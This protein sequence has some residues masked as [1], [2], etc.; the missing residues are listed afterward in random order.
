MSRMRSSKSSG[1]SGVVLR[2]AM[3]A[4]SPVAPAVRRRATPT[5]HSTKGL[6]N[7]VETAIVNRK[8]EEGAVMTTVIMQAVVSVDGFI[9]HEDDQPGHLFDW[10]G[11]GDVEVLGG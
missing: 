10:Y 7:A 2:R 5:A 1:T 8:V 3:P 9:A 6:T 4:F 11:N